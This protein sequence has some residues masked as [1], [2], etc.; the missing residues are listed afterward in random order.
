MA[1]FRVSKRPRSD[2]EGTCPTGD[3]ANCPITLVKP[4]STPAGTFIHARFHF[5]DAE[6]PLLELECLDAEL[7]REIATAM[8]DGMT[9]DGLT[10]LTGL[11]EP[12]GGERRTVLCGCGNTPSPI[13]GFCR[14]C[15]P[16]QNRRVRSR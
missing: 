4:V 8:A 1:D 11:S 7:A 15:R 12:V 2:S 3:H 6:E 10:F 9:I 13:D 5:R 16:R 14:N